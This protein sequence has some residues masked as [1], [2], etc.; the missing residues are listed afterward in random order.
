MAIP[1]KKQTGGWGYKIPAV[2]KKLQRNF[3]G[4]IKNKVEFVVGD[5]ESGISRGLGFRL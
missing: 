5:Q 4:L 1:E 2:L 3:Q